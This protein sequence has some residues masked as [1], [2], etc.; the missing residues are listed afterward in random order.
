MW[1]PVRLKLSV[2]GVVVGAGEAVFVGTGRMLRCPHSILCLAVLRLAPS[3]A[4]RSLWL[5]QSARD[6]RALNAENG[7]G[8][9]LHDRARYC[10][11]RSLASQRDQRGPTDLAC[12]GPRHEDL[13]IPPTTS[14]QQRWQTSGPTCRSA[15]QLEW[16][17][18]TLKRK[19]YCGLSYALHVEPCEWD[20]AAHPRV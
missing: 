18:A 8:V 1:C 14:G 9:V 5:P 17:S 20:G 16:R 10:P 7:V 12:I 2:S 6:L 11:D 15:G 19:G 4:S 13:P 3:R